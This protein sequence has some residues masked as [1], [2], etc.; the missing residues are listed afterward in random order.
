MA[1]DDI[2]G[3]G[4]FDRKL[5][6]NGDTEGH[7]DDLVS[8]FDGEAEVTEPEAV[9]TE[10]LNDGSEKSTGG[11]NQKPIS[12]SRQS[13]S[14]EEDS[15]DEEFTAAQSSMCP[16][17]FE[18]DWELVEHYEFVS[19]ADPKVGMRRL[20][21]VALPVQR[22]SAWAVLSPTFQ[23]VKNY[24]EELPE[25]RSNEEQ[26]ARIL[27][28]LQE[29]RERAGNAVDFVYRFGL[30]SVSTSKEVATL[31]VDR[32]QEWQNQEDLRP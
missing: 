24:L 23:Q 5:R 29:G 28:M 25:V 14:S 15:D 19:E 1:S 31:I 16:E 4:D 3:L 20:P 8:V 21:S 18:V 30:F 12:K 17:D 11:P 13:S 22:E 32:W 27:E 7:T 9:S 26:I 2:V 10:S 6:F